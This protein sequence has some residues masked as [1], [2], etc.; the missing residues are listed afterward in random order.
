MHERYLSLKYAD[1]EQIKFANELKN[2]DKGVKLIE[3]ISQ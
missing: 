3:N 2:L 1:N